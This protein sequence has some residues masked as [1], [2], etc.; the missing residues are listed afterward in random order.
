MVFLLLGPG[1]VLKM[2]IGHGYTQI[3]GEI[4]I[5]KFEDQKRLVMGINSFDHT[6]ADAFGTVRWLKSFPFHGLVQIY[7]IKPTRFGTIYAVVQINLS[8]KRK[9]PLNEVSNV[10]WLKKVYEVKGA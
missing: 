10:T 6:L 1:K 8:S 9:K 4:D 2:E 3:G 5:S 7:E